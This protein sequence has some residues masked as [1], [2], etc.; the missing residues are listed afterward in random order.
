MW[1]YF[2]AWADYKGILLEPSTACQQQTDGHTEIIREDV[3][4][5]VHAYELEEDAWI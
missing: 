2:H 4:T 5:L 1:D 3:V